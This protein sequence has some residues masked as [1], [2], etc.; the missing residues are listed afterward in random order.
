MPT[1]IDFLAAIHAEPDDATHKFVFANWPEERSD[2]RA[3]CLRRSS[4]GS[5]E[6]GKA[7]RTSGL[8]RSPTG[9]IC[10]PTCSARSGHAATSSSPGSA[11]PTGLPDARSGLREWLPDGRIQRLD[12]SR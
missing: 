9:P 7:T 10:P 11:C 6:P 8:R 1:E 5:S 12:P 3:A 4:N 2:P